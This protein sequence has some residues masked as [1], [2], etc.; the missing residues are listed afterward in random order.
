MLRH[1]LLTIPGLR[2]PK[3][4][5]REIMR[6]ED[7]ACTKPAERRPEMLRRIAELCVA[8][9]ERGRALRHF[10]AA[11]DMYLIAGDYE[12]AARFCRRVVQVAPDVV[13]ARCTLAFLSLRDG[14]SATFEDELRDYVTAAK[15]AGQEQYAVTRLRMMAS[16]THEDDVVR[17][18]IDRELARL[19]DVPGSYS[20]MND[21]CGPDGHRLIPLRGNQRERWALMLRLTITGPQAMQDDE[22]PQRAAS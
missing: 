9:G 19:G 12:E 6:L 21:G 7:R 4:L 14:F 18:L 5:R 11:I 1:L 2:S 15:S 22:V 20:G 3:R 16:V 13:R 10:G 17:R 8:A